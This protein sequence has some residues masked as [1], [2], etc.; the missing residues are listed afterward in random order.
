MNENEWILLIR[1]NWFFFFHRIIWT[2]GVYQFHAKVSLMIKTNTRLFTNDKGMDGQKNQM[3][4][5]I[6]KFQIVHRQ[7]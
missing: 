7:F 5:I 1:E 4:S 6:E 2:S 3:G